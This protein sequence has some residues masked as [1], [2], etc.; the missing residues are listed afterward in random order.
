VLSPARFRTP[1]AAIVAAGLAYVCF[2]LLPGTA[3]LAAA[4]ALALAVGWL[5]SRKG[6][7]PIVESELIS[8]LSHEMRTPL[9]GI[10]G[11]TQVLLDNRSGAE[12]RELL[13][14]IKA[15]GESLLRVLNDL[16]DF[17]K[18]QAGRIR[19]DSNEF[20]L[21][22]WV[23]QSVALHA[24]QVH[25]KGLQIS[26]WVAPDV[27]DLVIGDSQRLRQVLW[28][29]IANAIKF[30]EEGEILVE[31]Q[32][33]PGASKGRSR[34]R[35]S[36]AD[37]GV[38]ISQ[39]S[40][41]AIFGAFTQGENAKPE[42]G[43]LGLGLAISSEI[44]G[45][46][47]GAISVESE[48]SK[49]SRFEFEVELEIVKEETPETPR[50]FP[51]LRAL[52]VDESPWEREVIAKEIAALGMAVEAA[53]S[54]S[55]ARQA[56][57][58]ALECGKPH[59]LLLIDTRRL[60]SALSLAADV[61]ELSGIPVVLLL[62][63]HQRVSPEILGSRDIAGTLTKPVA[64][65]HLLRAIEI[66]SRGERVEKPE[67]VQT[68]GMD[69]PHLAGVR[70]LLAEDHPVNRT[71]VVR[72][73]GNQGASVV[74]AANG[75]EALERWSK[76]RFDILL[77]DL[78]MPEIDG[79]GVAREIRARERGAN[80]RLPII[81]LTAHAR[82]EQRERCFEAGMDGFVT[83]PF[84]E[85]ELT[86]VLRSVLKVGS[87]G[88]KAK[89]SAVPEA[90]ALAVLDRETAIARTS[91]DR[92]LLAELTAIFL[93]ETPETL[94]KIESALEARDAKAVERLAHCLKGALLTLAAP[95][96]ARA[97]LELENAAGG[98]A[99]AREALERL[100]REVSRLEDELKS[101]TLEPKL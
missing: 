85:S 35:F 7:A 53:S 55:S 3:G 56:L 70:V 69:R 6:R 46:M 14:M 11:L 25:R 73:L 5:L 22:R 9:N 71:V 48:P 68:Q 88:E 80:E 83:K 95:A 75:R 63:T 86:S 40:R 50:R 76:E 18:I 8:N 42:Q 23:R 58:S 24:P 15:S 79:L 77:L 99:S 74:A 2:R 36:V 51:G 59:S 87:G 10:L 61:R 81:A 4:L 12:E 37:T 47:G 57:E 72:L 39:G 33:F 26:Y 45:R 93:K 84:A 100:R 17:S 54:P 67:D 30:T 82:E 20:R 90:Q 21:R 27:P 78:E 44:V 29:L 64:P 13:E 65:T 38:G 49:G 16:L 89:A 52:V 101:L 60:E 31:V 91:G 41:S 98:G 28:N 94:S 1:L 62:P 32:A 34:L 96:A 97:A 43:G 66:L 92:A 19:L